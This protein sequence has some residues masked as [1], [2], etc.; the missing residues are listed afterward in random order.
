MPKDL[1]YRSEEM[2]LHRYGKRNFANYFFDLFCTG[3][4]LSF[5]G[6]LM[7]DITY[8]KSPDMQWTNFSAWLLLFAMVFATAAGFFGLLSLIIERPL[9]WSG[10]N[11]LYV[12]C[13]VA[14]FVAGLFNNFIHSRDAWTSVMPTGV[15]LSLFTVFLVLVAAIVRSATT[16]IYARYE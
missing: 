6:A 14:I 3:A 15:L 12:L 4:G 13:L 16:N 1:N 2:V 5:I 10:L 9:R 11:W 8:V 7:T